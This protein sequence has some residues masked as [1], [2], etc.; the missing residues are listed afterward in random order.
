MLFLI[1]F[2]IKIQKENK[3]LA[4]EMLNNIFKFENENE[5]IKYIL[6]K[7]KNKIKEKEKK[8]LKKG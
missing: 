5:Y 1:N 4:E 7:Y 3:N 2:L 8:I 6:K